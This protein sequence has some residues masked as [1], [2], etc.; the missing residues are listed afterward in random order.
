MPLQQAKYLEVAIWLGY[1]TGM[2]LQ[3]LQY[4]QGISPSGYC[5]FFS[6]GPLQIYCK[7]N[8]TEAKLLWLLVSSSVAA[9]LDTLTHM[10]DCF[11][12]QSTQ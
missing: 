9:G 2:P 5:I 8:V 10:T 1:I 11:S 6:I 12:A 7:Q 4:G 3:Q